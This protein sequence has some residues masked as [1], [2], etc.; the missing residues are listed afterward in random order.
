MSYGGNDKPVSLDPWQNIVEVRWANTYAPKTWRVNYSYRSSKR[1]GGEFYSYTYLL[2]DAS[3]P[4][5]P[6]QARTIE[7][8]TPD[9][10]AQA[11]YWGAPWIAGETAQVAVSRTAVVGSGTYT[12]ILGIW[13]SDVPGP[14]TYQRVQM[15]ASRPERI[16]F[17][18]ESYRTFITRTKAEEDN[19]AATIESWWARFRI[20]LINDG[21]EQ[22]YGD[23]VKG[24]PYLVT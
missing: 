24:Q 13:Y 9:F 18:N 15:W 4:N 1:S 5:Q 2:F 8:V 20:N 19:L 3:D 11:I 6:E 21:L 16:G 22:A 23:F 17:L 12:Y 14:Y 7:Q 10:L